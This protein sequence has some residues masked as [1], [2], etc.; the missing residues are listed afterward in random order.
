MEKGQGVKHQR[1][2]CDPQEHMLSYTVAHKQT[3]LLLEAGYLS[4]LQYQATHLNQE[5]LKCFQPAL[6]V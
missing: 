4:A 1:T 5:A 6:V 2:S 3:H